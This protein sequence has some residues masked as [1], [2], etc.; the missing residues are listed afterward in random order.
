MVVRDVRTQWNYTHAMIHRALLLK[1]AVNAWVF[2]SPSLHGCI[3]LLADWTLLE[4]LADV[5][6]ACPFHLNFKT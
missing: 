2:Q 1:E 4:Q 5:L 3:L 6:E